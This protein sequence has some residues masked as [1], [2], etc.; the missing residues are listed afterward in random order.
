ML[1]CK[2]FVK[3]QNERIDGVEPTLMARM[4]LKMHVFI[5]VHCRR[6]L[7]QLKLVDAV[8]QKIPDSQADE[9][10]IQSHINCIN[11]HHKDES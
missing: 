4:S 10:V 5:C 3:Q 6:Y 9:Q 11:Q 2:D 1:R 7:A 8:S